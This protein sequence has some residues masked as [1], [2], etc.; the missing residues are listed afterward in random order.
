LNAVER[1]FGRE[2]CLI[3]VVHAMPLPGSSRWG[4]EFGAVVEAAMADAR[5]LEEA[6]FD[7]LIVEN[8]GDEPFAREFAGR[9]AVAGLAAIAARIADSI[10]LP[11]GVNV[12]RNDA[13]SAVAIAAA[14]GARFIRVNVH[15][16]AAVT[17]QGLVQ[18]EARATLAAIRDTAPGLA[19]FADVAVKHAVSLGAVPVGQAARDAVERGRADALIVTGVA[20]GAKAS[21]DDA[22]SVA[23]AVPGTPVLIGSGV[24]AET[25]ASILGAADGIIVGS[26]LMER[27]RAGSRIEPSRAR[28][29]V[30]AA[31]A[32]S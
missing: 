25:A 24:T 26:D 31:R 17:D 13:L 10:E 19:V 5:A 14:V 3:G 23:E 29:F 32:Q 4:G 18:G 21:L 2:K 30:E 16:G 11:L 7:G 28:A 20:T 1:I 12:L 22:R 8:Y 27:G 9:G 15:T 6:G